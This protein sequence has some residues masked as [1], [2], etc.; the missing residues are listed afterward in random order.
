ME[1]SIEEVIEV[2]STKVVYSKM[3]ATVT[4]DHADG[5]NLIYI[6]D[7]YAEDEFVCLLGDEDIDF[8]IEALT[9][10]KEERS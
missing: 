1:R 9:A 7:R 4:V 3:G 2:V 10:I 6:R 5:V 8:V